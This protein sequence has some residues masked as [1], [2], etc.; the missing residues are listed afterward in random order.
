VSPRKVEELEVRV[1]LA[2]HIYQI[3]LFYLMKEGLVHLQCHWAAFQTDI[4]W[5]MALQA[6]ESQDKIRIISAPRVTT[7]DNIEAEINSGQSAVIV[8]TGDN[9]QA[10]EVDTGIRLTVTPHITDNNMVFM[11]IEVEK[12]SLGQVTA[13]TVTTEEKRATTQVLLSDGE[14]T[15]IGGILEDEVNKHKEGWPILSKIPVLGFFFSGR[16]ESGTKRELM[17]F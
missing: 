8:P 9:T 13:N 10:E 1:Y 14:T 15:V 7:L 6:L 5:I 4:I 16:V 17:V 11:D 3:S 12:S 2:I